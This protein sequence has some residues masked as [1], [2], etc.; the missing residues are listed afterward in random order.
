MSLAISPG[1]VTAEIAK[2]KKDL[3]HRYIAG[4]TIEELSIAEG[5]EVKLVQRLIDDYRVTRRT[6]VAEQQ[7]E[8]RE[9]IN[10]NNE[11]MRKEIQEEHGPK[12]KVAIGKLLEGTTQVVVKDSDGN[13]KVVDV[14]DHSAI[15]VGIDKYRKTA[16]LEEKPAQ[17]QITNLQQNNTVNNPT[18]PSAPRFDFETSIA[19]LKKAKEANKVEEYLSGE[20]IDVVPERLPELAESKSPAE[21]EPQPAA[22]AKETEWGNF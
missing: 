11:R 1:S 17:V 7:R 5:M 20:T 2:Q 14:V 18:A 13:Q 6:Q 8:A 21:P 15:A 3:Y 10:A 12:F 19:N 4:E 22:P 16:S 9:Q